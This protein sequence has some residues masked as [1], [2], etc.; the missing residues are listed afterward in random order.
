MK[1]YTAEAYKQ[2][3]KQMF[4]VNPSNV[5]G[6]TAL[7]TYRDMCNNIL[8]N[9]NDKEDMMQKLNTLIMPYFEDI[10]A[11]PNKIF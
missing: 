11:N 2:I 5:K 4:G 9:Y 7:G 10:K 3:Y 6:C 8:Y 1:Q